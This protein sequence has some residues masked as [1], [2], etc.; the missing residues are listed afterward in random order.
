[1][2]SERTPRDRRSVVV[3]LIHYY[4]ARC[5]PTMSRVVKRVECLVI[6]LSGP[7]KLNQRMLFPYFLHEAHWQLL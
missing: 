6:P 7:S 3:N 1:M 2:T 4:I 5:G